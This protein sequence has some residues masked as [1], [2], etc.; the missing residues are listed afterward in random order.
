[1]DLTQQPPR[2]PTNTSML[3]IVALARMTDKAR[4]HED[5]TL[6]EYIYG[7]ASGLDKRIL[8]FLNISEEDFADSAERFNDTELCDWIQETAPNTEDEIQ[9]HSNC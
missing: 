6:G 4:A 9:T 7:N 1:M 3:G 2:R 5:E 8:E